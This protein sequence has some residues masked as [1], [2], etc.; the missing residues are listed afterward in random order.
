MLSRF[1]SILKLQNRK[2]CE[3]RVLNNNNKKLVLACG[4]IKDTK[5]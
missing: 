2:A 3:R 4:Q 1:G 5:R